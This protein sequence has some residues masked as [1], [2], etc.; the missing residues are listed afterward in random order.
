MLTQPGSQKSYILCR[1][2]PT[3][4]QGSGKSRGYILPTLPSIQFGNRVATP[5]SALLV[6]QTA[7]SVTGACVPPS[8]LHLI[9]LLSLHHANKHAKPLRIL[10]SAYGSRP[11]ENLVLTLY[12][13]G[14]PPAVVSTQIPLEHASQ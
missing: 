6:N 11:V 2:S 4:I 13:A 12:T 1:S 7:H 3:H 5:I 10:P 8:Q 9:S 14:F